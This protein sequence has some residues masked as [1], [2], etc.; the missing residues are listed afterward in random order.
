MSQEE[1]P[2]YVEIQRESDSIQKNT[3]YEQASGINPLKR[4]ANI[5]EKL[6]DLKPLASKIL[7][8]FSSMENRPEEMIVEFGVKF[9]AEGNLIITSGTMETNFKISAKWKKANS[10]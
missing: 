8:T 4:L 7:H 3:A 6:S 10:A 1:Q 9:S 5:D 2:I